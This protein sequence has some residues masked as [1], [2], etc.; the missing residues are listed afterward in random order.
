MVQDLWCQVSFFSCVTCCSSYV[1]GFLATW[2]FPYLYGC[3]CKVLQ[4]TASYC[5]WISGYPWWVGYSW[6][7]TLHYG[8]SMRN[9]RQKDEKKKSEEGEWWCVV[10]TLSSAVC[11]SRVALKGTAIET[12]TS[13]TR[14]E[15][16]GLRMGCHDKDAGTRFYA[17]TSFLR[18]CLHIISLPGLAWLVLERKRLACVYRIRKAFIS[19]VCCIF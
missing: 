15:W 7:W 2:G 11:P 6:R 10:S 19:W 1:V 13:C 14:D 8:N 4:P 12:C 9:Q 18:A 17:D 3:H 16:P 5:D